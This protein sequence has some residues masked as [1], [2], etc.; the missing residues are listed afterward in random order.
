MLLFISERAREEAAATDR[1][2]PHYAEQIGE[3]NRKLDALTQA[4]QSMLAA[5]QQQ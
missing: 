5:Q 4:L 3:I 1:V 2:D